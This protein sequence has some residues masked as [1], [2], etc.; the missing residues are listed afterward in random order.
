MTSPCESRVG[1]ATLAGPSGRKLGFR[2]ACTAKVRVG[3]ADPIFMA[4]RKVEFALPR[5][6]H[7]NN[8]KLVLEYTSASRAA[9]LANQMRD[10]HQGDE[11]ESWKVQQQHLLS[12]WEFQIVLNVLMLSNWRFPLRLTSLVIIVIVIP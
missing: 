3:T 2:P 12:V 4:P 6:S 9:S 1:N 5:D 11:K 7:Q 10:D 8:R